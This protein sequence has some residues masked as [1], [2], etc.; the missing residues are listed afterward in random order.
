MTPSENEWDWLGTGAYF[1][2]SDPLR[3]FEWALEQSTR[4]RGTIRE[5]AVIGAAID[6]GNCLDLTSRADLDLVREA[7]QEMARFSE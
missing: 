4:P 5:S 3:A 2:E 1:W 6:L 7:Y